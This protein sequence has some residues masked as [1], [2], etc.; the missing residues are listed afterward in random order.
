MFLITSLLAGLSGVPAFNFYSFLDE[1]PVSGRTKRRTVG[2]PN[3][4]M[5]ELQLRLLA[6]LKSESHHFARER[7][8]QCATGAMPGES[9][10]DNVRAHQHNRYFYLVDFSH[11]YKSV[12]A[13]RLAVVLRERLKIFSAVPVDTLTSF[14]ETYFFDARAGLVPGG[15]AS[16]DL[17]NLYAGVLVDEAFCRLIREHRLTYTRYIDD[18]T[19]SS[20]E[21]I[22]D[23]V[24][25]E[26]RAIIIGAGFMISHRKCE[27]VDLKQRAVVITGYGLAEGG[28][29]FVPRHYL[30]RVRLAIQKAR[31]IGG[32]SM[33][34]ISGMM[35]LPLYLRRFQEP[36]ALERK[37]FEEF[38]ALRRE[39]RS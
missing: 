5:R 3:D 17:F 28:R 11:A 1:N 30:K 39:K 20:A 33:K 4:A 7:I 38:E 10:L 13:H 19:F 15:N 25:R 14:C 21:P 23:K 36:N 2:A 31:T 32:I 16:Q 35:T 29:I 12:D 34:Q 9:S 37:V 24:R 27:V 6:L 18:L 8:L 26:I 22:S